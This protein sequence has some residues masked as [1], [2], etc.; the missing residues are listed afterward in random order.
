[1]YGL[2]SPEHLSDAKD[3]FDALERD[4]LPPDSIRCLQRRPSGGIFI[5]L[6][7]PEMRNDFLRWSSFI[8]RRGHYA[9]NDDDS[10]IF[11]LTVYNT[12]CELPDNVIIARLLEYCSV[13]GQRR[14]RHH[15]HPTVYNGLR[16]YRIQLKHDDLAATCNNILCFNC[17]QL[18]HMAR[19]CPNAMLCCLCKSSTHLAKACPAA[20]NNVSQTTAVKRN[21]GRQPA[22][23]F[24][25]QN[26]LTQPDPNS[27]QSDVQLLQTQ[28]SDE[29]SDPLSNPTQ[30]SEPP[31]GLA[32]IS[33]LSTQH[34]GCLNSQG[35]IKDT[36]LRT[37]GTA[38]SADDVSVFQ[39]SG[40]PVVGDSPSPSRD[41]SPVFYADFFPFTEYASVLSWRSWESLCFICSCEC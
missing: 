33:D 23:V 1:M 8:V 13:V 30:S 24:Q 26:D 10:S 32:G 18:G 15:L 4:G 21:T 2:L 14:G 20:W 5:T 11:Y 31:V 37:E 22:E 35:L 34:S 39:A 17:D 41:V 36:S 19:E 27:N 16:H 12:P 6:R 40:T 25:P 28:S 7:T 3:V 38:T 29:H 9:L